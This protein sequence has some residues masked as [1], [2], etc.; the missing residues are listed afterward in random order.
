MA[1]YVKAVE[2]LRRI[3]N[4]E[5]APNHF[6]LCTTLHRMTGVEMDASLK[7]CPPEMKAA[8]LAWPEHSG[9]LSYP[10]PCP[11]RLLP[12]VNPRES[13]GEFAYNCGTAF[14]CPMYGEGEYAA[15][16]RDLATH[17]ADEIERLYL[18]RGSE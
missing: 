10:V 2:V 6:G 9:D 4:G 11:D 12:H 8:V 13:P 5:P 15:L 17:V 16:R 14:G 1:D 3:A 18:N 7:S